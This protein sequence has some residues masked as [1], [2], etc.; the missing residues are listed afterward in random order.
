[1]SNIKQYPYKENYRQFLS[2]ISKHQEKLYV[3]DIFAIERVLEWAYTPYE[4]FDQGVLSNSV[5]TG[6]G[7]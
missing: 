4:A 7:L 5:Y 6:D 1:M 2:E 3:W